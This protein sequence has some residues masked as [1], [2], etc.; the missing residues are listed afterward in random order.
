MMNQSQWMGAWVDWAR[1]SFETGVKAMES[2]S[3]QTEKMMDLSMNNANLIQGESRK[4]M[5]N[6]MTSYKDYQKMYVDTVQEGLKTL[7]QQY[8]SKSS[9]SK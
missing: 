5:E 1:S 7:E 4:M 3:A 9:K 6:W 8:G 2:F